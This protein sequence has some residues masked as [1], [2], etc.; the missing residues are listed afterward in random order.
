MR[1]T[2]FRYFKL[3]D[4]NAVSTPCLQYFRISNEGA[5]LESINHY[6]PTSPK[7]ISSPEVLSVSENN[8]IGS[9]SIDP[10]PPDEFEEEWEGGYSIEISRDEYENAL[11]AALKNE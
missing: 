11:D 4:E 7:R 8:L 5:V 1:N 6:P 3:V 10:E 9:L 2:E